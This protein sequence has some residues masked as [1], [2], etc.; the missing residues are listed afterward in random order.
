ML[1]REYKEWQYLFNSNVNKVETVVVLATMLSTVFTTDTDAFTKEKMAQVQRMTK[2][3]TSTCKK[4]FQSMVAVLNKVEQ[5]TSIEQMQKLVDQDKNARKAQQEEARKKEEQETVE[6]IDQKCKEYGGVITLRGLS[7]LAKLENRKSCSVGYFQ[8]IMVEHFR[9]CKV[10]IKPRLT[11]K[12][13]S[14]RL[15]FVQFISHELET[16]N[17]ALL[18]YW[19]DDTLLIHVD[20]KWFSAFSKNL[21]VYVRKGEAA[22][23]ITV[24]HKG[25]IPKIMFFAACGRP[26]FNPDGTVRFDGRVLFS[27]VHDFVE[28]AKTGKLELKKCTMNATLFV[29]YMKWTTIEAVQ[30]KK[31]HGFRRVVIQ[32]DNAGGH[33]GGRGNM[34]ET[35]LKK[36]HEWAQ[37][38]SQAKA[39]ITC[40]NQVNHRT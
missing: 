23:Y 8:H 6:W 10:C 14:A 18:N 4:L 27:A 38:S 33:G 28:K 2:L 34:N 1:Q 32:T 21:T 31:K 17:P 25:H 20:E 13:L 3:S 29:Q 11:D 9:A 36:L 30:I 15:Q 26:V 19:D 35:V 5:G 12:H 7:E 16:T 37:K 24:I 39:S 22:P 40:A